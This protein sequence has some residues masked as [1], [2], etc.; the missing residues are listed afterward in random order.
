MRK[1]I[2]LFA[3]FL[4]LCGCNSKDVQISVS[5]N[6]SAQ[7][8]EIKLADIKQ[9][10]GAYKIGIIQY[11]D[12][13]ELEEARRGFLASM[14]GSGFKSGENLY[15]DIQYGYSDEERVAD[16]AKKYAL[17]GKNLVVTF[18][19]QAAE[20]A[21]KHIHGTPVLYCVASGGK[22]GTNVTGVSDSVEPSAHAELIKKL[23]PEA[24][25]VAVMY[26]VREKRAADIAENFAAGAKAYELTAE[27]KPINTFEDI[28]QTARSLKGK[29]DAVFIPSDNTFSNAEAIASVKEQSDLPVFV[30]DKGMVEYGGDAAV[31]IDYNRLGT[32]AGEMA[33][34]I[35]RGAKPSQLAPVKVEYPVYYVREGSFFVPEDI[36]TRVITIG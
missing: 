24:K 9:K 20:A 15:I 10:Q 13:S 2:A 16:V 18:S 5:D 1:T 32:L 28:E 21:S 26:C 36:R 17:E 11:S 7:S 14:D 19:E 23:V 12:A 6:E 31:G 8:S 33:G 3:L 4:L 27:K 25:K 30:G 35:L 34:K 29:Y 22:F